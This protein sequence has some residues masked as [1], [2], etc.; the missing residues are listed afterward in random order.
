MT[1]SAPSPE[2]PATPPNLGRAKLILFLTIFVAMLGLSVL[3]PIFGPL[4][5]QLG[6]SE[7]QTGWFSTAYSLMQFVFS[8]IW[9]ALRSA[10]A[11][12]RC[13]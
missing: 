10:S 7:S 6:L 12:S 11:A 3:F 2:A 5:R 13:W 9:G 8:P 4:S 1:A